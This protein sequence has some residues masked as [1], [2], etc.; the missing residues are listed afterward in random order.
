MWFIE[1]LFFLDFGYSR[2]F[3]H[4][5]INLIL[6]SRKIFYEICSKN[7]QTQKFL[8]KIL[9]FFWHAEISA[10]ESVFLTFSLLY[11]LLVLL[12]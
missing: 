4:A 10:S 2:K 12:W 11:I 7:G 8:S 9:R 3:F 5:K 6:N 1:E